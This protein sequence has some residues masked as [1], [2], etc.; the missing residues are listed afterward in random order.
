[1]KKHAWNS[2][3]ISAKQAMNSSMI[4]V[5][6]E[7]VNYKL[8]YD[9]SLIFNFIRQ[10]N[11]RSVLLSLRVIIGIMTPETFLLL[12]GNCIHY[13]ISTSIWF[14]MIFFNGF[15]NTA[16][17]SIINIGKSFKLLISP[18]PNHSDISDDTTTTKLGP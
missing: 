7:P 3:K 6:A 11:H 5:I 16:N 2:S 18:V 8:L 1:M 13:Q 12:R 14:C 15:P 9:P 17:I 10:Q 4:L